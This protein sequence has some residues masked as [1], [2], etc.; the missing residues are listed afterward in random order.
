MFSRP[1]A[2]R[3][4]QTH[5]GPAPLSLEGSSYHYRFQG[6]GELARPG[7]RRNAWGQSRR[8]SSSKSL[9][10]PVLFLPPQNWLRPSHPPPPPGQLMGQR[11]GVSRSLTQSHCATRCLG[12][13]GV[14]H[15]PGPRGAS[16]VRPAGDF[17]SVPGPAGPRDPGLPPT[18]RP[19]G[20]G[21]PLA[22]PPGVRGPEGVKRPDQ[23]PGAAVPGGRR[24]GPEARGTAAAGGRFLL[25]LL[26]PPPPL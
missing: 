1:A 24:H 12:L 14:R 5:L 17:T 22:Q 15:L 3:A 9:S 10:T 8:V 26:P 16:T 25:P 4:V 11:T 18:P 6:L 19:A 13:A 7:S 20:A 23:A 21:T 2:P